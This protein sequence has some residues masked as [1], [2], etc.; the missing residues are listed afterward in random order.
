MEGFVELVRADPAVAHGHGRDR[1]RVAP[2][3]H[4]VRHA[5]AA[6]RAQGVGGAGVSRLR[7]QTLR[8]PGARLFLFPVQDVRIGGRQASS[9][10]QYTLAQRRSR[11]AAHLDAAPAAGAAG[12]ARAAGRR[13]RSGDARAAALA[14]HRPARRLRATASRTDM[15]DADARQR[16]TARRWFRPSTASR[17]QYRVVMEVEER[18][19]RSP[20]ALKA[21]LRAR[22]Q[23]C[24]RCRCRRSRATS[25]P[26][27]RLSVNHQSQFAASTI[28][29][30]LA[31]G[32]SLSDATARIQDAMANIGMPNDDL[33]QLRGHGAR[34][35][36]HDP[37]PAVADPRGDRR[38]VHRARHPLREPD[39]PAHHPVDPAFGR[40]RRAAR[41]DAVR[42]RVRRDRAD[43]ACSC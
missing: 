29:F 36:A 14:R 4:D 39:P 20:E 6:G 37:V 9:T 41:A 31:E 16:V 11:A 21:G 10:Y 33:R 34:L 25:S 13:Q 42:D 26:T 3:G 12:R 32:A 8:V 23:R 38:G 30:N 1:R 7:R 27:R 18:Y 35:P 22:A 28:S 19:A 17:N 40:R 5:Q 15:I 2:L 24:D 43:R